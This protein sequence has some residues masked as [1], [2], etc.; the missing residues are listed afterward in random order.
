MDDPLLS[1]DGFIYKNSLVLDVVPPYQQSHEFVMQQRTE[2]Y[3]D[4]KNAVFVLRRATENTPL[5]VLHLQMFLI[6]SGMLPFDEE[7]IVS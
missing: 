2:Q 6:Q 1:T 3:E 7:K 5:P 4:L